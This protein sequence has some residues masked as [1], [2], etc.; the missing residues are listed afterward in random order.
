MSAP[1]AS[2]SSRAASGSTRVRGFVGSGNDPAHGVFFVDAGQFDHAAVFAE[3][4]CEALE[5]VLVV[6]VHAAGVGGD[7]E[8]VGDEDK[9]CLGVGRAEVAIE[10]GELV[11]FGAAGVELAN[12]ADEDDLEGRHEGGGLGAIEDL[13]NRSGG[14]VEVG[15]AEVAKVGRNEG[16]EDSRTATV[17]EEYLV[18]GEDIAG[19]EGP[20]AG[21]SSVDFGH[22]TTNGREARAPATAAHRAK[23]RL[24]GQIRG[25][26]SQIRASI[27]RFQNTFLSCDKAVRN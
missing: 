22:K 19:A 4:F 13:E 24:E 26:A 2:T 27:M 16:T 9:K 17:E 15:E 3:S 25:R 14:E 8:E 20:G 7:A 23:P 10:R 6:H 12:V 18:A 1:R 21:S 5:A 11:L